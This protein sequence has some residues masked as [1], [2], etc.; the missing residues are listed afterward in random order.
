L[1][2]TDLSLEEVDPEIYQLI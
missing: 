1:P 2:K